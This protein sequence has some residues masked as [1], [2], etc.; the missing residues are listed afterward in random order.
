MKKAKAKN[1]DLGWLIS[2]FSRPDNWFSILGVL[3]AFA[4]GGGKFLEKKFGWKF[5]LF[6][7][8]ASV[9]P[10]EEHMI[11]SLI[12]RIEELTLENALLKSEKAIL[13]KG[14]TETNK[15]KE[16]NNL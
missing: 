14:H 13:E 7:G 9:A 16:S 1:V 5:R 11:D 8:P 6:A 12:E 10:V 4:I 3:S 15:D 2:F